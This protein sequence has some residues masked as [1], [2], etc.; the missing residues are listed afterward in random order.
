M[1]ADL[2]RRSC[3][4]EGRVPRLTQWRVMFGPGS[5]LAIAHGS[6]FTAHRS[7]KLFLKPL[8]QVAQT[9]ANNAVDTWRR[10]AFVERHHPV[11]NDLERDI[12][13]TGGN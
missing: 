12:A 2:V 8:R 3:G 4:A 9:P 1:W 10:I 5:K 13:E 7:A 6:D 11:P